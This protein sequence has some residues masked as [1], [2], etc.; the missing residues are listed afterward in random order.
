MIS[1]A[2]IPVQPW[3]T[4]GTRSVYID[5]PESVL[6]CSRNFSTL[7]IMTVAKVLEESGLIVVDNPL[8]ADTVLKIEVNDSL[9]YTAPGALVPAYSMV[10]F[11]YSLIKT[12]DGMILGQ[13]SQYTY[14]KPEYEYGTG[15][16]KSND[17]L[18]EQIILIDLFNYL[19]PRLKI[20]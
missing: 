2:T 12:Q 4:A 8:Q 11:S 14:K 15:T 5:A 13:R 17:H 16:L 7:G 3:I 10:I 18:P 20:N 6:T 1:C 19:R 9:L